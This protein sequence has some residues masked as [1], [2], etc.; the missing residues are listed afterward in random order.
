MVNNSPRQGSK[1]RCAVQRIVPENA[2]S[3]TFLRQAETEE[4]FP[5]ETTRPQAV[6]SSILEHYIEAAG[7]LSTGFSNCQP[8]AYLAS[9]GTVVT[10][11]PLLEERGDA[12][13]PSTLIQPPAGVSN[14]TAPLLPAAAGYM[15]VRVKE[16][17][18]LPGRVVLDA[19]SVAPV[20]SRTI[21]LM[22][23]L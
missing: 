15:S 10:E 20:S 6:D 12:R 2:P 11:K 4:G 16:V 21:T 7:G 22:F 8:R 23:A 5:R 9:T 14:S 18:P 13:S 1:R 17:C 19:T 3:I